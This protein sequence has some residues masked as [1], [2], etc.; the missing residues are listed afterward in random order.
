MSRIRTIKPDFWVSEQIV[1]CSPLARLLF[2]G[3]WNFVDDNGVH[4]AS[5]V[6][7]KAEVFPCDE[8]TVK[9]IEKLV[10]ELIQ[11]E[12]LIEYIVNDTS[13]WIVTG[14]KKH[15]R[16]DKPTFRYPLPQSGLKIIDD[17]STTIPG[18]INDF[19]KISNQPLDNSSAT[20][21]NGGEG[22]G[23]EINIREETSPIDVPDTGLLGHIQDIFHYWQNVM[24]HPKAK[25][26]NKR[27][28]TIRNA[29]KNYSFEEIKLAIDGCFNT[30][31]NMGKNENSEVYDDISLILRDANHIERFMNNSQV[32]YRNNPVVNTDDIMAGV[33]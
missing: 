16:I 6:R 13:Y 5:L 12:L 15:Q 18:I 10:F 22:I 29:L 23:K 14:W 19:S 33:I 32:N 25:L 27:K 11:H 4:K 3:M 17:N 7:L 31:Y 8:L 1:S 21:W 28:K 24:S 9:D 26:D 30:P 2:I 20:E